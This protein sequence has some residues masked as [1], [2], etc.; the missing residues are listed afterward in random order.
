MSYYESPGF[1]ANPGPVMYA[2]EQQA[3][4]PGWGLRPEMAGPSRVGVGGL[5]QGC[6]WIPEPWGGARVCRPS[7]RPALSAAALAALGYDVPIS[8]MGQKT[9]LHI[10]IEGAVKEMAQDAA[11][12][13]WPPIK[14]K[15]EAEMPALLNM[16]TKEVMTNLVPKLLPILQP[17]IR[18]EID[19]ALGKA[20]TMAIVG[21]IV[22]VGA[23]AGAALWIKKG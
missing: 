6:V 14:K 21:G 1:Y 4:V 19:Y 17:A 9:T 20:R 16:A 23:L 5:G 3:P 15:V 7:A 2:D 12:A 11:A 22:F 8:V 18:T 13:A 10:G